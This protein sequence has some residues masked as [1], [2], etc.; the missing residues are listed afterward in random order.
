MSKRKSIQLDENNNNDSNNNNNDSN[1]N[2]DSNENSDNDLNGPPPKKLLHSYKQR[3]TSAQNDILC[4]MPYER[5]NSEVSEPQV[6]LNNNSPV[7]SQKKRHNSLAQKREKES[8]T[9]YSGVIEKVSLKN[10]K[11]HSMLEFELGSN[12][13]FILGR[14]GSKIAIYASLVFQIIFIYLFKKKRW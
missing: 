11:C 1:D 6:D 5:N 4:D 10:F 12:I 2:N 13:N 8:K 14:N 9:I 7:T 3:L